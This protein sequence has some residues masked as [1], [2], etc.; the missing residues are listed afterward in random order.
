MAAGFQLKS[1]VAENGENDTRD[2]GERDPSSPPKTTNLF[3][4][5]VEG[6]LKSGAGVL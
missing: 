6:W 5:L 3:S 4:E 1:L 2:S